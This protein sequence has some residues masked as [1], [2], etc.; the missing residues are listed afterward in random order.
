MLITEARAVDQIAPPVKFFT[1]P[2]TSESEFV[3][4]EN[5]QNITLKVHNN[6]HSDT[7]AEFPCTTGKFDVR[8][9]LT[10][11]FVLQVIT[12]LC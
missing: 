7:C 6:V 4:K 11:K 5:E 10:R 3:L 12:F 8:V 1:Q 9:R 2:M